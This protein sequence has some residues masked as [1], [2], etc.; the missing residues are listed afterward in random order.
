ALP[1]GQGQVEVAQDR[2]PASHRTPGEPVDL[3]PPGVLGHSDR[4]LLEDLLPRWEGVEGAGA[5]ERPGE[6]PPAEPGDD[7]AGE[8]HERE[9]GELPRQGPALEVRGDLV[10][11]L[12]GGRQRARQERDRWSEGGVGE[13]REG[14][15]GAEA[16]RQPRDD[17]R[18]APLVAEERGDRGRDELAGDG[19][20]RTPDDETPDDAGDEPEPDEEAEE[21]LEGQPEGGDGAVVEQPVAPVR[22]AE[23]DTE[24][25]HGEQVD[26]APAHEGA[27]GED[28]AGARAAPGFCRGHATPSAG[29]NRIR[30]EGLRSP[31]L[32]ALSRSPVV[33]H[34]HSPYR[35]VGADAVHAAPP[36]AVWAPYLV[37]RGP[38]PRPTV[39]TKGHRR[40][41]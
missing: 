26:G 17:R 41:Q 32:S 30:Y 1:G 2:L 3:D 31:A 9:V 39:T 23:G 25:G 34:Q 20:P 10:D 37:A 8:D 22:D 4:L 28:G 38:L 36:V 40:G 33:P 6:Q 5:G 27:G 15:L 7:D 29:A 12:E 18:H 21:R 19:R 35:P 16:L 24:E 13:D 14:E 11:P